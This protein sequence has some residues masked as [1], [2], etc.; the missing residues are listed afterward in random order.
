MTLCGE[1]RQ[2]NSCYVHGE[3]YRHEVKKY[4]A[5]IKLREVLGLLTAAAVAAAAVEPLSAITKSV[6][7]LLMSLCVCV[8][9][10]YL[11]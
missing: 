6:M 11:F 3:V 4:C 5:Q 7:I 1:L 8:E 2:I 10:R 9:G